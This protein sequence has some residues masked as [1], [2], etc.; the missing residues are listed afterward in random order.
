MDH[1]KY[2]IREHVHKAVIELDKACEVAVNSK[3][4]KEAAHR[5]KN[6]AEGL[7]NDYIYPGIFLK[8]IEEKSIKLNRKKN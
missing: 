1:A 2:E 8:E 7:L 4:C 3:N 5:L 6:H